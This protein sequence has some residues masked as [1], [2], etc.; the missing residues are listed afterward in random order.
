MFKS[1]Y[2]ETFSQITA[3]DATY[4]RILA[5]KTE[6]NK[7][8]GTGIATKLLIAAVMISLLAITAS[9]TGLT[10]W[11]AGFFT[12]NRGEPLSQGQ[13][14]Y[15]EEKTQNVDLSQTV[16][17]YTISLKQAI[18]DG[19]KT[20][21]ALA[22]TAP[23][24]TD[25]S[26]APQ[27]GYQLET[28]YPSMDI[29]TADESYTVT[30][31][32]TYWRE[33]NDGKAN[34]MDIAMMMDSYDMGLS[35]NVQWKL[36]V[37]GLFADCLNTELDEQLKAKYAGQENVMYTDEEAEALYAHIP[38][39]QGNWTFTFQLENT[40]QPK[41]LL[42]AP[43][44]VQASIGWTPDGQDVLEEITVNSITLRELSATIRYDGEY[45]DF[46]YGD[47]VRLGMH[48][49]SELILRVDGG[50]T[51]EEYFYA[52]TPIAFAEVDY[53]IFPDGTK[54]PVV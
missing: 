35:Q 33:D 46:S 28:V 23:E 4:R 42:T 40:S 9:A 37:S 27:E 53:L 26:H 41:E 10:S 32:A 48:D 49:G 52:D 38:L 50:T 13:V 16:D 8:S 47:R 1:D 14:D 51:G 22:V 43:I 24:G 30:S 25:L 21:V 31:Y 3:S 18:T 2:Q 44:V 39:V 12:E 54:V 20:Y 19:S 45:A 29:R 36:S 6:K 34:T 17:G 7:R 11:F 5:M 15:I